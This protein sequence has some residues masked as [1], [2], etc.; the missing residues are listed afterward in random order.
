VSLG[1]PRIASRLSFC[2]RL[3][4]LRIGNINYARN[5]DKKDMLRYDKDER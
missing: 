3:D 2:K 4:D 1:I 5:E